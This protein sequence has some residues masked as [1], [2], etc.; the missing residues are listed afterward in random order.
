[1]RWH[2]A[3]VKEWPS[4]LLSRRRRHCDEAG[5]LFLPLS[6]SLAA[7]G[8]PIGLA[9]NLVLRQPVKAG[10]PVRWEDVIYDESNQAI[11]VRRQMEN[12][13]RTEAA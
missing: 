8:L 7:G 13:F 3:E 4:M 6:A 1:M 5:A 10:Q 12:L 9:H 2:R 11:A